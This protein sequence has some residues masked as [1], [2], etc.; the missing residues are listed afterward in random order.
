M[1]LYIMNFEK[2]RA[3]DNDFIHKEKMNYLSISR[4][5]LLELKLITVRSFNVCTASKLE[6]LGDIFQY[7]QEHKSFIGCKYVGNVT[8]DNLVALCENIIEKN[9][10]IMSILS[11]KEEET[12][13]NRD[14]IVELFN[15]FDRFRYEI[16]E[17]MYYK[18]YSSLDTRSQ[19]SLISMTPRAFFD[20]VIVDI[21]YSFLRKASV[22]KKTVVA[23]EKFKAL[24]ES[25][26]VEI[27]S[28]SDE[29]ALK[30]SLRMKYGNTCH[31]IAYAY[32][33]Y[34]EHGHL[35][36]FWI[37]E[38]HLHESGSRLL[39]F[40]RVYIG[41]SVNAE[42]YRDD[43][44]GRYK[45]LVKE[46]RRK[47]KEYL[48]MELGEKS[49]FFRFKDDWNYLSESLDCDILHHS[50]PKIIELIEAEKSS[51]SPFIAFYALSTVLSSK[52]DLYGELSA[53]YHYVGT[54]FLINKELTSTFNFM[55]LRTRFLCV[56]NENNANDKHNLHILINNSDLWFNFNPELFDRI[57]NIAKTL[58]LEEFGVISTADFIYN[59]FLQGQQHKEQAAL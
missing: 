15:G 32:D 28:K 59:M 19:N 13:H 16:Y 57:F 38:Q 50:S 49:G 56:V 36:M 45:V 44:Y 37:L 1:P 18:A 58:L 39:N 14:K 29:E 2:N 7:Y 53:N 42:N 30:E 46:C 26:I 34:K 11:S 55:E 54:T 21:N 10:E 33:F 6:T 17:T 24:I 9:E 35:P 5:R 48:K 51:L 20:T 4:K 43:V 22:G 3:F 47:I 8:N 27:S 23:L 31:N 40:L 52:M 41:I 25:Y 12:N